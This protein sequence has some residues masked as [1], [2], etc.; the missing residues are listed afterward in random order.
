MAQAVVLA[1]GITNATSTDIVVTTTPVTVCIYG[2][3]GPPPNGYD[4][5]IVIDAP[6]GEVNFYHERK[7]VNLKSGNPQFVL[8]GPGTYR[9]VRTR[10]EAT[11]ATLGVYTE[12]TA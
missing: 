4:A 11:T 6:A 12:T 8:T 9:V 3:A 10:L 7:S 1:L 2:A 5:Q